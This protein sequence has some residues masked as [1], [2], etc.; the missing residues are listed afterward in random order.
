MPEIPQ[1]LSPAGVAVCAVCGRRPGTLRMVVATPGGPTP[2]PMC[3]RCAHGLMARGAATPA[4]A[5]ADHDDE[6]TSDTPTLDEFGRDLTADARE[7]RIDPVIVAS[8]W[9]S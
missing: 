6:P 2:V 8:W 1:N 4:N 3:E 7:G 9:C 5:G